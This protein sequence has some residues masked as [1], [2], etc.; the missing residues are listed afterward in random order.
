MSFSDFSGDDRGGQVPG[1][2]VAV[3]TDNDDPDGMA[4]VK[5]SYPWRSADDESDWARIAV[6]MAGGDRGTYFLPEV[7]DEV[8]VAFE[9]DDIHHPVVIG[10]LWNGQQSP[11]ET[12]QDGKNDVRKVTSRAGHEVVLDDAEDGGGVSLTTNGGNT[13]VLDDTGGG[14]KVEITDAKGDTITLDA[15]SGTVDVSGSTTVNVSAP[16][17]EIKSD[18]NCSI[19]ASGMLTLKGSL[20]KIN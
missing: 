4:R 15:A 19:E 10:A 11:P 7:D 14:E 1:V 8:L 12:N 20:V 13:V 17:I 5:L 3:V 18:G 2:A 9:N 6:P 16:N